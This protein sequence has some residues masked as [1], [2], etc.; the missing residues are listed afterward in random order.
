MT[1]RLHR[2]APKNSEQVC[3]FINTSMFCSCVLCDMVSTLGHRLLIAEPF[4]CPRQGYFASHK[5]CFTYYQCSNVGEA[6]TEQQCSEGF[7]FD[8]R[9]NNCDYASNVPGCEA[10]SRTTLAE[11]YVKTTSSRGVP[12]RVHYTR[13]EQSTRSE[14]TESADSTSV[15]RMSYSAKLGL[16]KDSLNSK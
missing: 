3:W 7:V 11:I 16:T 1:R 10:T 8:G 9:T 14:L 13:R 12:S 6:P 15:S 5:D 2:R 4:E